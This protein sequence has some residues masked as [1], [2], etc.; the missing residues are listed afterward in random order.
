MKYKRSC[1]LKTV[2]LTVVRICC[3]HTVCSPQIRNA[4]DLN[5]NV[6]YPHLEHGHYQW[7][8]IATAII[9]HSNTLLVWGCFCF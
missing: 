6:S 7:G 1:S 8:K 9:K 4:W 3:L 5:L 2:A